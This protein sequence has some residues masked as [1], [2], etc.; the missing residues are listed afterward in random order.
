MIHD[1]TEELGGKPVLLSQ[2]PPLIPRGK[3]RFFVDH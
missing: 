2:G 1:T 3:A